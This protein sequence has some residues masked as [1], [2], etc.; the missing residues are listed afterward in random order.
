VTLAAVRLG[1]VLAPL[2]YPLPIAARMATLDMLSHGQ[3]G[4][5]MDGSRSSSGTPRRLRSVATV[6]RGCGD[7][8]PQVSRTH[9]DNHER[10]D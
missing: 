9:G 2:H 4:V 6:I 8:T 10:T 1:M 7:R 3:V 5:G